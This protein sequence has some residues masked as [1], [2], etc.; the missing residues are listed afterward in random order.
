MTLQVRA[1]STVRLTALMRKALT[2][3]AK[4]GGVERRHPDPDVKPPWPHPPATLAALLRHELVEHSVDG[5]LGYWVERWV[6]LEAGR[7]ALKPKPVKPPRD[8]TLYLAPKSGYT[9]DA[10][11][12]VDYEV[13]TIVGSDG[14]PRLRRVAVPAVDPARLDSEWRRRADARWAKAQDP[15]VRARRARAA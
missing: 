12:S 9:P 1:S 13:M 15:R 11:R 6:I 14:V 10:A 3:A 4:P 7:E 8:T 2:D 5:S